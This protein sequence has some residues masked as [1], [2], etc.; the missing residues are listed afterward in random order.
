MET[1][2][3][4]VAWCNVGGEQKDD[5]VEREGSEVKPVDV[6]S[7]QG[8]EKCNLI[9]LYVYLNITGRFNNILPLRIF[10]VFV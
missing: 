3:N 1:L 6:R 8:Q 4:A 9:L 7:D 5:E 10:V 2:N